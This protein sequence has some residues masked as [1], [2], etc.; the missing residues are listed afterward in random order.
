MT[1]TWAY[2]ARNLRWS[3]GG[4]RR[5]VIV[6]GDQPTKTPSV[7]AGVVSRP[8]PGRC[9]S[10]YTPLAM[11]PLSRRPSRMSTGGSVPTARPS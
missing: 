11:A 4:W 10:T 8:L 7:P 6:G 1:P 5:A 2:P 3:R 9:A